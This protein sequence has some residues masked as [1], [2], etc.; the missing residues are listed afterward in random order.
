M[1]QTIAIARR[2]I[3]EKAFVFI[4]ALALAVVACLM[5]F[6]PGVQNNPGEVITIAA[7]IAAANMA[8]IMSLM[9]GATVIGREMADRRLSFY[10]AK[11]IPAPS[12][13]FGKVIAAAVLIG[14][15]F[16]IAIFPALLTG[17]IEMLRPT[18]T[19]GSA[20][21]SLPAVIAI[22]IT[23]FFFLAHFLGTI[24]RS[25]S[26]WALLDFA[27]FV[28]L[29][30]AGWLIAQPLLDALGMLTVLGKI[31]G[32]LL[33]IVALAAGAW[34]L[35]M[36]RT[37]RLQSHV[38]MSQFLWP[39][40]A[41][42]LAICGAIV[43]WVVS[44]SP[45]DLTTI[46]AQPIGSNWAI[47]GGPARHRGDYKAAYLFNAQNGAY[48]RIGGRIA[49]ILPSPDG[50]ALLV[51][52]RLRLGSATTEVFRREVRIGAP[53]EPT[54]VILPHPATDIFAVSNDAN[55]MAF[56]TGGVIG[57]YDIPGR[58]SLGSFRLPGVRIAS[59]ASPDVLRLYA[60]NAASS[61]VAVPREL[62]I[63]EYDV[64][65]RALQQTGAYTWSA[66]MMR[67]RLFR[68]GVG[69][70]ADNGVTT[71]LDPRTG[72][73]LMTAP[74]R[75]LTVLTDGRVV[76]LRQ[77]GEK[78]SNILLAGDRTIN[79]GNVSPVWFAREVAPGKVLV[80]ALPPSIGRRPWQMLLI[81]VD[82]GAVIRREASLEPAFLFGPSAV[83]M[84]PTPPAAEML[85]YDGS[86]T[87]LRWNTLTGQKK[88]V[89]TP[90]R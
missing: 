52:K 88:V 68:N 69:V 65:T 37:D 57:L 71:L 6:V 81:D 18:A 27:A 44:A 3:S 63:Y 7:G 62:R 20:F 14:G 49:S 86:G 38:A 80:G 90:A 41:A 47:I 73:P 26:P 55:R 54:G 53:D 36:G 23:A 43:W 25:R 16:A 31:A 50:T 64:R 35:S 21:V 42:A 79:L 9:L 58:R 59:F 75:V 28:A 10:F 32:S 89:L 34:Q 84:R 4:A 77:E 24:V 39:A 48:D 45:S 51:C 19:A 1:F 83:V 74:G 15:A 12:I 33:L 56:A 61:R 11:P 17:R 8:I 40:A 30:V 5:P 87:L 76:T 66:V 13:W 78:E 60:A 2:E 29:G 46:Y 82:R 85:V 70:V 72:R 67:F 22:M